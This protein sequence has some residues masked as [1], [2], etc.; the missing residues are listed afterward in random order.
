MYTSRTVWA[1]DKGKNSPERAIRLYL[2]LSIL[3]FVIKYLMASFRQISGFAHVIFLNNGLEE[4]RA[5]FVAIS[6]SCRRELLKPM[7]R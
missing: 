3:S 1:A 7:A 2:S 4:H 5:P 6:A